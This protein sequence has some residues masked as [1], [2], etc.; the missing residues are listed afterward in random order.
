MGVIYGEIRCQ[1]KTG[2]YLE[3]LK[4]TGDSLFETEIPGPEFKKAAKE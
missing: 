3:Y 1:S 2:V 4:I